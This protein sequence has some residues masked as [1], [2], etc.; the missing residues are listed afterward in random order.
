MNL[1]D[2][3]N[4]IGVIGATMDYSKV[5][6]T[7]VSTSFTTISLGFVIRLAFHLKSELLI[8]SLL[9]V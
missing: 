8:N 5:S 9:Y 1:Y 2:L 4:D 3:F 7:L 6:M